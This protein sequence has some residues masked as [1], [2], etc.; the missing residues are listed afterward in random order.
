[1]PP[2]WNRQSCRVIPAAWIGRRE[3]PPLR[4]GQNRSAAGDTARTTPPFG[5]LTESDVAIK[6]P[7]D[8]GLRPYELDR[9][10][11]RPLR[12]PLRVEEAIFLE[13]VEPVEVSARA[14]PAQ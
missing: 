9:L 1:M 3:P 10:L 2:V 6:S 7:A 13:D 5:Q 14:A 4:I 8:G 11:G 12:R